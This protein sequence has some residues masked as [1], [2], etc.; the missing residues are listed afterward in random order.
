KNFRFVKAP[1]SMLLNA[2]RGD[3]E[4]RGRV[5]SFKDKLRE[6]GIDLIVEK[7]E[8][9]SHMPEILSLGIDYGQGELFGAPRP[10]TFYL[11]P[12]VELAKAS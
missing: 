12:N 5:A 3:A 11:Q 2:N 10:A 4:T 1:S 8:L 9:E 6:C 7:V